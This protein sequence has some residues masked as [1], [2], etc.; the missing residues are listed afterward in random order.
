MTE[1]EI[2]NAIN[3][4]MLNGVGEC[5]FTKKVNSL[6]LSDYQLFFLKI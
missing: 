3:G 4:G 2:T 6:S 1:V 5:V